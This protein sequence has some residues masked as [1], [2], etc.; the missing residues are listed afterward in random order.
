MEDKSLIIQRTLELKINKL[1]A[2]LISLN[3]EA[4]RLSTENHS[5]RIL[6]SKFNH[7][8]NRIAEINR[9]ADGIKSTLKAL[10]DVQCMVNNIISREG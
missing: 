8:S 7:N 6:H 3:D 5:P 9:Q 4:V 10:R 1:S 2:L